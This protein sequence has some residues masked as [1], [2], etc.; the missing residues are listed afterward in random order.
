MLQISWGIQAYGA[1]LHDMVYGHSCPKD[2]GDLTWKSRGLLDSIQRSVNTWANIGGGG[3]QSQ[4]GPT[5]P[6]IHFLSSSIQA[7][8]WSLMLTRV[9]LQVSFALSHL[10]RDGH[11]SQISQSITLPFLLNSSPGNMTAVMSKPIC[12]WK[13]SYGYASEGNLQQVLSHHFLDS[14]QGVFE[15]ITLWSHLKHEHLSSSL[16]GSSR[17]GCLF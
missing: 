12:I 9:N 14:H 3:C 4:G 15:G 1:Y 6:Q 8:L 5:Q 13:R 17:S 16:D 10:I 11:T 7:C 2:K